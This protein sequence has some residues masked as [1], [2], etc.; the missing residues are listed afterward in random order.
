V[1]RYEYCLQKSIM[2]SQSKSYNNF[3]Q[4]CLAPLDPINEMPDMDGGGFDDD[5]GDAGGFD[6]VSGMLLNVIH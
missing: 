6:D 1:Q 3:L 4:C 2:Q 5:D